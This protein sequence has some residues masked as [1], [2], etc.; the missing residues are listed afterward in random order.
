[1]SRARVLREDTAVMLDTNVLDK[2]L[3]NDEWLTKLPGEGFKCLILYQLT[4]L[5]QDSYDHT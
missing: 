2:L 4:Y 5:L 1:M 3:N